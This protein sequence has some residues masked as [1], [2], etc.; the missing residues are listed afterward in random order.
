METGWVLSN[1]Q[2][3]QDFNL[4]TVTYLIAKLCVQEVKNQIELSKKEVKIWKR[5]IMLVLGDFS[6][7]TVRLRTKEMY[8]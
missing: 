3:P 7:N 1:Y 5:L 2:N 4:P 6:K 8:S